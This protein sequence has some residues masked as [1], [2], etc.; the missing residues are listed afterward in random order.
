[1]IAGLIPAAGHSRRMGKPKLS[2]PV[3]GRTVL[4]HVIQ[5]LH[6]VEVNPILVV[7]GP[8][9]ADLSAAA[10]AAG[11]AVLLLPWPTPDMRATVERGLGWIEE[12]M[13][14]ADDNGLLLLPGDHPTLEVSVLRA[15]LAAWKST[16]E[17][18]IV[19]PTWQG[20]R[21]HPTLLSWK[22]V[23]GIR[24]LPEGEGVNVYLRSQM[25]ETIELPVD[26][27]SVVEDLDTPEDYERLLRKA[28]DGSR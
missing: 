14:P 17:K 15:L 11:A 7:L 19:V 20:C 27:A 9:V 1:M 12:M 26:S 23:R 2:L 4:E 25:K 13:E 10:K 8:H 28:S 16:P 21:G 22:H 24:A 6:E 3:A 5:A 18:S